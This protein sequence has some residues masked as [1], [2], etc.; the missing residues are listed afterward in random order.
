[1]RKSIRF[2]FLAVFML[3]F[4]VLG[5]NSIWAIWNFNSL[6]GSIENI[7]QA[8]YKSIVAAQNM[9]I[10]LERQDSAEL[11]QM[12]SNSET[13]NQDFKKNEIEFLK[14]LSRAE[15]NITEPGEG[16]I[17]NKI[18]KLYI[19]YIEAFTVF[20]DIQVEDINKSR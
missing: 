4:V 1:M 7:M 9:T 11:A 2:K 13:K 6:S 8:N 20:D 10:A 18:N 14:W 12:F 3:I 16:E 15:D 5:A 19:K 17:L